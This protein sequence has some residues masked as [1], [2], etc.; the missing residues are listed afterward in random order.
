MKLVTYIRASEWWEYKFTPVLMVVYLLFI[1]LDLSFPTSCWLF[2]F[3]LLSLVPGGIFVSVLNDLTDL[4]MDEK[5]GKVNRM[6]KLGRL[7]RSIFLLLPF[8]VG[9]GIS[10]YIRTEPLAMFSYL[11]CGFSFV[12][13]SVKPFRLKEKGIWGILA[14]AF[15]S[16]VFPSLYATFLVLGSTGHEIS[17]TQIILIVI[18]AACF[19]LRGILWHQ[20][21]DLEND[22]KSGISTFAQNLSDR[23]STIAG[24]VLMTFEIIALAGI[25]MFSGQYWCFISLFLYWGYLLM[26]RWKFYTEIIPFRYTRPDYCLFMNEYYQIFLPV[27]LLILLSVHQPIFS[28]LLLTHLLL[29]PVGILQ[30]GKMILSK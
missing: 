28:I 5:A 17:N 1:Q 20:F 16:Q 6:Q 19:G 11:L 22:I 21:H 12:L 30:I 9:L 14:D 10:W 3:I 25:T 2:I 27:T 8:I 15:G 18:W 29:F 23:K 7:K 26:R 4:K 13:Y 24:Y